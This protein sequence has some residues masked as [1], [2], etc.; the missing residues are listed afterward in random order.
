M[1]SKVTNLSSDSIIVK[2]NDRRVCLIAGAN[3]EVDDLVCVYCGTA[4]RVWYS[5]EPVGGED[6]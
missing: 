1:K 3:I 6:C 4:E 2:T 5:V